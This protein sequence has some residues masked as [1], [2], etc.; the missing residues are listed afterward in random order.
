MSKNRSRKKTIL[1]KAAAVLAVALIAALAAFFVINSVVTGEADRYIFDIDE[2]ENLDSAD[3]V[4]VLGAR[5]YGDES[6]SA[7]LKDRVDYAISIY[8]AGK[9]EKLLFS[10]DHGQTDY[11]EVNAMMDYA[12]EKGV[13]KEDIFLD[14][15]GFSTYESMYRARDVFCVKSLI[16]ITQEFHLSR[17]V[18]VARGLGLT[19]SGVNSDPRRYANETYNDIRES[20]ARV[21]DFFYVNIFL[22]EPKY[23]GEAIPIFGDS[24]E[25]HDKG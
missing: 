20:L 9:A 6:L 23:L 5:V 4:L 19:A 22:P 11:D 17:A 16:I 10:G 12:V 25:T 8:E 15:A 7:V 1:L 24:G 13:P 21:K 18:Y 2:T 14:H 3:C